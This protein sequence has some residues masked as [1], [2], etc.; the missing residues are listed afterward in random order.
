MAKTV[1][2]AL[3]ILKSTLVAEGYVAQDPRTDKYALG[4][5]AI[6]PAGAALNQ[7]EIR[8]QAMSTLE[9]LAADTSCNANLAVLYR[10]DALY[11]GRIDGPKSARMDTEERLASMLQDAAY[12]V[13]GRL[14][15]V[16]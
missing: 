15:Y 9:R 10:G 5:Q 3:E 14:G 16:A 12:E 13:S 11:V 7:L 8:K 1:K 4:L 6:I 2:R